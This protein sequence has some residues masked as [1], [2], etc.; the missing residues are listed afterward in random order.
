MTRL[1]LVIGLTA[2]VHGQASPAALDWATVAVERQAFFEDKP[3]EYGTTGKFDGVGM[4]YVSASRKS[5]LFRGLRRI[6]TPHLGQPRSAEYELHQESFTLQSI[7]AEGQ[8]WTFEAVNDGPSA[9]RVT[10]VLRYTPSK[11]AGVGTVVECKLDEHGQTIKGVLNRYVLAKSSA[12]T[13]LLRR[14][15]VVFFGGNVVT[16]D[17]GKLL[18]RS[19]PDN[20]TAEIT[21]GEPDFP[22]LLTHIGLDRR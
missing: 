20:E 18:E 3:G 13:S 2:V 19:S 14:F 21:P 12:A 6:A 17:S 9:R 7:V 8:G 22:A 11:A 16:F 15:D 5:I 1:V 10:G 4:L